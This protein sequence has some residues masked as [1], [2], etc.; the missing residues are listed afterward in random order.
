MWLRVTFIILLAASSDLSRAT[1]SPHY[2]YSLGDTSPSYCLAYIFWDCI[3]YI[4]YLYAKSKKPVSST[5]PSTNCL[6]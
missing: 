2:N 1:T 3:V 5:R 6:L 4:T